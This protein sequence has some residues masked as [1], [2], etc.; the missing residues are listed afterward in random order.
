MTLYENRIY[1]PLPSQ[2]M[3][4]VKERIA[5]AMTFRGKIS[6]KQLHTMVAAIY[7]SA[8]DCGDD[9]LDA[10]PPKQEVLPKPSTPGL[11]KIPFIQATVAKHFNISI[12]E[13]LSK[14][15]SI[16]IIFPRQIAMYL[17][18]VLTPH[19]SGYIGKM[20]ARDH[21]TTLHAVRK[22]KKLI[23]ADAAVAEQ[24]ETLKGMLA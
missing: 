5:E 6:D 14:L 16:S 7:G 10:P 9:S 3:K 8:R 2:Q 22:I 23:E 4:P 18:H 1:P 11:S 15:R 17:S 24:I 19:S 20:F 13:M 12:V 21:T